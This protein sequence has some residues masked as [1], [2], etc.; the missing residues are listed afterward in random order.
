MSELGRLSR[1]RHAAVGLTVVGVAAAG[2]FGLVGEDHGERFDAK[3]VVVARAGANSLRVREV[4]DQ[5]FGRADRRGYQRIIPNDFGVPTEVSASSPDAPD[6]VAVEQLG[7]DTRIRIG[8]PAVT[9]SGQHRYELAYT[10]PDAHLTE[11]ELA[12]DVIGTAE[13]L[14][15]ERFEVV[16]TGF[17]LADPRC[18]VGAAGAEGGCQLVRD[19]DVYR[20]EISP[21][22]PGAGI[23][24]GGRIVA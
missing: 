9:V 18:N 14:P 21:L 19:G 1:A 22:E 24:I 6:D 8:D 2:F 7:A 11:G 4:V 3:Q 17:E 13:E 5:D 23:T 16:V 20:A 15:T 12:L 10:Y